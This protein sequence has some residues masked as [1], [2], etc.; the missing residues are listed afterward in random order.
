[1]SYNK[2]PCA[3]VIVYTHDENNN[4]YV[5][6]V[7]S[8]RGNWSYPKG[9]RNKGESAID[10][11]LRELREETGITADQIEL[12]DNVEPVIENSSKGNPSIQPQI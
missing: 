11:G 5:S 1:M 7:R 6:I 10:A 4:T 3:G 9:K 2:L 12:Q 8:K